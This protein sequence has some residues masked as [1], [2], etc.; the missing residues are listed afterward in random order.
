MRIAAAHGVGPSQVVLAWEV[1]RG[2]IPLPKA[3]SEEHQ[4]ENLAATELRLEEQEIA[5]ITALGRPDG[6][7]AGQDPATYE[8]F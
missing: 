1:S 3:T 7:T 2:T 8:E 6:R 5:E 4:R